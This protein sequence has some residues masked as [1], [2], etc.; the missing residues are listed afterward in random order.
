MEALAQDLAFLNHLDRYA[1]HIASVSKAT[2][3]KFA[4]HLWYLGDE[5]IGL[6]LFDHSVS[7]NTKRV[8]CAIIKQSCDDEDEDDDGNYHLAIIDSKLI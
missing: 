5:I 4:L 1:A 6:C 3:A 2:T 7:L 8:I